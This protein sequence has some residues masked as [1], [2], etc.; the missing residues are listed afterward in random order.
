VEGVWKIWYEKGKS[1]EAYF[2]E[3]DENKIRKYDCCSKGRVLPRLKRIL[4]LAIRDM[5]DGN[6]YN[7]NLML[8]KM[9]DEPNENWD[10][11][12]CGTF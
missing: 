12:C 8:T 11:T 4:E 7:A 9:V 6:W 3:S 5:N 2:L 10:P 1:I